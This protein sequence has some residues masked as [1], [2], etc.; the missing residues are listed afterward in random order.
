[1]GTMTFEGDATD[2]QH[3]ED[4][5]SSDESEVEI[6]SDLSDNAGT[7]AESESL[8]SEPPE[9]TDDSE[10]EDYETDSDESDSDDSDSDAESEK[11]DA[12]GDEV[13]KEAAEDEGA[14]NSSQPKETEEKAATAEADKTDEDGK[15][16]TVMATSTV[17]SA[18]V[19]EDAAAA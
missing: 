13:E 8:G 1:M 11:D 6:P 15:E 14:A 5:I 12:D 18:P 19:D 9:L 3:L 2:L 7:D 4:Q 17:D 10:L 16:K